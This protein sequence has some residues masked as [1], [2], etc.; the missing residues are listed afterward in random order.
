MYE[1]LAIWEYGE[2]AW[3]FRIPPIEYASF[4]QRMKLEQWHVLRVRHVVA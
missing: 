3:Y 2:N 1:V 4:C